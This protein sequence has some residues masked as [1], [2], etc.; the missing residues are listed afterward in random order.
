MTEHRSRIRIVQGTAEV[1]TGELGWRRF[2]RVRPTSSD[3]P[4][5]FVERGFRKP[6]QECY[7][8]L[9]VGRLAGNCY[10]TLYRCRPRGRLLQGSRA[11][12]PIN[13]ACSTLA[14][15]TTAQVLLA[16]FACSTMDT[17]TVRHNPHPLA[18]AAS[19]IG[20]AVS[21]SDKALPPC[22]EQAQSRASPAGRRGPRLGAFTGKSGCSSCAAWRCQ[23][24][25][26]A[27]LAQWTTRLVAS[28]I[29]TRDSRFPT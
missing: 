22:L 5:P 2:Q 23:A 18:E 21:L 6:I 12:G 14:A 27:K 10:R 25:R 9:S 13:P 8:C 7:P 26:S 16:D 1:A 20:L 17:S 15:C 3:G 28:A 19:P 24:A 29:P 11:I 4:N